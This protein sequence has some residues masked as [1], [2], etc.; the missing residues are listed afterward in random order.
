MVNRGL[1]TPRTAENTPWTRRLWLMRLRKVEDR[2]RWYVHTCICT[3]TEHVR[4]RKVGIHRNWA[5]GGAFLLWD[6][7]FPQ[8]MEGTRNFAGFC[9]LPW[10]FL[11]SRELRA[12]NTTTSPKLFPWFAKPTIASSFRDPHLARCSS[13]GILAS[14]NPVEF[15][16][17]HRT[18]LG[19]EISRLRFEARPVSRTSKIA[20]PR[21]DIVG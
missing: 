8:L 11:R 9:K 17:A 20:R 14:K 13:L 12:R 4:S 19:Q 6:R 7:S 3:C 2:A 5:S 1:H 15:P 21:L 18:R 10:S 16:T